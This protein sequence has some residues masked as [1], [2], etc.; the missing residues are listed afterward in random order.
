M[1]E[2]G[3]QRTQFRLGMMLLLSFLLVGLF[4]GFTSAWMARANISAESQTQTLATARLMAMQVQVADQDL[5]KSTQLIS[6]LRSAAGAESVTIIRRYQQRRYEVISATTDKVSESSEVTGMVSPGVRYVMDFGIPSTEFRLAGGPKPGI[7]AYVP[8]KSNG[9]VYAV[10]S[11]E[12]SALSLLSKYKL[13]ERQ[14]WWY[15]AMAFLLCSVFAFSWSSR[16]LKLQREVTWIRN[17]SATTR[18]FNATIL[19]LALTATALSVVTVGL[20]SYS[21]ERLMQEQLTKSFVVMEKLEVL[22]NRIDLALASEDIDSYKQREIL[23]AS[24]NAKDDRISRRLN[25]VL[26]SRSQSQML[27]GLR[28]VL[29]EVQAK[30]Q[31]ERGRQVTLQNSYEQRDLYLGAVLVVSCLL[32]IG[33]LMLARAASSQQHDLQL[34][35]MDSQRHKGAYNQLTENLP[36]GLYTFKSG[37]LEYT[38]KTWNR[39]TL[40][41]SQESADLAFRRSLHPEDKDDVLAALRDFEKQRLPFE[42]QYRMVGPTGEK[43]IIETRGVPLT[44]MFGNFEHILGFSIDVT[45]RVQAQEM[46][47]ERNRQMQEANRQLHQAFHDVELNFEAMVNSLVRA[48]EAKDPYTAGHSERVMGYSVKIG[49]ALGYN[50]EELRILE[51]GCLVHDIGKIGIPDA[52]LTKPDRLLP[53]EY[54]II[55]QHPDIGYRM[56]KDIPIFRDCIP[57]VRWHHERLDGLGYPDGLRGDQIP[58][59]VR[60]SSVADIFDAL[61]STRAYRQGM[62]I[63]RAL[64]ILKEEADKGALDRR[65]V[66]IL[67]D[68][69]MRE[70]LLWQQPGTDGM[71]A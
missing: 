47:E 60:I 56:I 11:V 16:L 62:T 51:R 59:M 21:G 58:E 42:M 68:I 50:K 70:G 36:V 33:S 67:A 44:D 65:L 10:L 38:N 22:R 40:R 66:E 49:Q 23:T 48:V 27:N 69:V 29:N 24:R 4:V 14:S 26:A 61:T 12:T 64:G 7:L 53:E 8:L 32:V 17:L 37:K 15:G 39:Q 13:V 5:S 19:E 28:S 2:Q 34:A 9:K 52:I 41:D 3:K 20:Y 57:I 46:A 55:Q 31:L 18:F 63:D 71:A 30:Q 35:V 45:S 43:H 25:L 6:N 1:A 54:K